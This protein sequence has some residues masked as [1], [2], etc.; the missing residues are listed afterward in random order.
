[1]IPAT[2][3]VRH[4]VVGLDEGIGIGIGIGIGLST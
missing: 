1:M 4:C 3:L 2:I